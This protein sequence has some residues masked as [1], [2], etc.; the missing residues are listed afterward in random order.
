MEARVQDPGL[1]VLHA[2]LRQVVPDGKAVRDSQL[3]SVPDEWEEAVPERQLG[4]PLVNF[5]GDSWSVEEFLEVA[6][7]RGVR[8]P[9]SSNAINPW[10]QEKIGIL[11]R[12][13]LL[14]R[15]GFSQGLDTS[16]TVRTRVNRWDN[17]FRSR[18]YLDYL[19]AR[20]VDDSAYRAMVRAQLDSL[21]AALEVSVDSSQLDDLE[22]TPMQMTVIK[23]TSTSRLA[24]PPFPSSLLDLRIDFTDA[25][26]PTT[27]GSLWNREPRATRPNDY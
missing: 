5:D 27:Q 4:K 1:Q 21:S 16:K 2:Y 23:R 15:E 14:A 24:V 18:L 9:D 12:D 7:G 22:I 19:K 3:F 25:T 11:V 6:Y 17:Y 10:I 20:T 8:F 13:E 26:E